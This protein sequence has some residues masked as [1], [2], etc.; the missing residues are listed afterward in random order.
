MDSAE[1]NQKKNI[2]AKRGISNVSDVLSALWV[3]FSVQACNGL[4][5]LI[6]GS[7]YYVLFNFRMLLVA[8]YLLFQVVKD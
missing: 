2:K 6:L 1:T 3:R 8:V 5:W 4:E 7:R